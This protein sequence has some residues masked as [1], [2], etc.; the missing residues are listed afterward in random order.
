MLQP[1]HASDNLKFQ[2]IQTRFLIIKTFTFFTHRKIT[3][4]SSKIVQN[5]IYALQR[6]V[7]HKSRAKIGNIIVIF[8][9]AK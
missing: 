4:K 8:G 7:T 3:F 1:T 6:L 2:R 9:D 5:T